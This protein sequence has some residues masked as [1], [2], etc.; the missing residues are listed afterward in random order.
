MRTHHIQLHR[1]V[2]VTRADQCAGCVC[3]GGEEGR[4]GEG[5]WREGK[6]GEG[7]GER[8]RREREGGGRAPTS[9]LGVCVEGWR[10]EG[11]GRGGS[12]YFAV[13]PND[14]TC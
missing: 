8:E 13:T 2:T 10:R 9:V 5:E 3:G 11:E 14:T 6:E 4:G 12:Q 7:G 1:R